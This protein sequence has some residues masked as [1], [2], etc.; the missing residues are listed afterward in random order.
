[1]ATP[2]AVPW[3]G[4]DGHKW[5]GNCHRPAKRHTWYISN[6]SS[7][8]KNGRGN[9]L[10]LAPCKYHP[11]Y[12]LEKQFRARGAGLPHPP[13]THYTRICSSSFHES[14]INKASGCWRACKPQSLAFLLQWPLEV[15]HKRASTSPPMA[16]DLCRERRYFKVL[17]AQQIGA[18]WLALALIS[19]CKLQQCVSF[20]G[21]INN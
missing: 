7:W 8:A 19:G 3:P 11:C 9:P 4:R 12:F 10:L 18:L 16:S 14:V 13:D 6:P 17:I 5:A 2:S 1:M 20:L 15:L 21:T